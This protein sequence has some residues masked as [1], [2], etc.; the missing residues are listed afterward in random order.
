MHYKNGRAAKV[1][2]V[3]RGKG[4]NI[5]HE[6]TGLLIS[7]TPDSSACNCTIATVTINPVRRIMFNGNDEDLK[8]TVNQGYYLQQE[9]IAHQEYGQLDAF[10][11]LDPKTGEVLAPESELVGVA[12]G[13]DDPVGKPPKPPNPPPVGNE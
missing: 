9:I 13:E 1:G 8:T 12:A 10:E 5:G 4:Y 2:D 3:V 6:I 11:A 7:A